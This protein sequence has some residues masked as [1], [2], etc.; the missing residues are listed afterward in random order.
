MLSLLSKT[1]EPLG[2]KARTTYLTATF[3]FAFNFGLLIVDRILYCSTFAGEEQ[4]INSSVFNC[5]NSLTRLIKDIHF[6]YNGFL[7][8]LLFLSILKAFQV[9]PFYS[10]NGSFC[11]VR[12]VFCGVGS[13]FPFCSTL[14]IYSFT[15]LLSTLSS[16]YFITV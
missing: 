4:H 5:P 16:C 6:Q 3:L 1:L 14:S 15:L 7:F 9:G 12:E 13:G 2:E 10:L 11:L 8:G